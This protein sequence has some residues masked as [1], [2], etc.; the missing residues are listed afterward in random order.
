MV[1]FTRDRRLSLT[2]FTELHK[3]VSKESKDDISLSSS[4]SL[5]ITSDVL[6]KSLSMGI[7]KKIRNDDKMLSGNQLKRVLTKLATTQEILIFFPVVIMGPI[8]LIC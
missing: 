3:A 7:C 1:L 2:N 8:I 6:L 5:S 4:F